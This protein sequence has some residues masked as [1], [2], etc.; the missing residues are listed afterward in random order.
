MVEV[1]IP[2][3]LQLIQTVALIVGIIYYLIIMRNS[4]RNQ[5]IQLETRQAQLFMQIYDKFNDIMNLG[6]FSEVLGFVWE[7]NDDFWGRF[8]KEADPEA[9]RKWNYHA[10]FL[11][12]IGVLVKRGLID[13]EM[14][15]D[16]MSGSIM[17]F[18]ERYG[19]VI[20][21]G[22][23]RLNAIMKLRGLR[24]NSMVNSRI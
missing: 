17:M 11:E 10:G 18:W 4:Q 7:D 3:V 5:Q 15:D 8:S 21:D 23:R 1:T 20:I 16:L 19:P 2:I 6:I 22:R 12:G 13:P 9:Y 24:K 14:V